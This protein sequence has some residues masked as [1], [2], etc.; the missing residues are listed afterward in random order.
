VVFTLT[1][2]RLPAAPPVHFVPAGRVKVTLSVSTALGA[3]F[4]FVVTVPATKLVPLP[5]ASTETATEVEPSAP[6]EFQVSIWAN[7]ERDAT[8]ALKLVTS[9]VTD[10]SAATGVAVEVSRV[11]AGSMLPQ[12]FAVEGRCTSL[13][14]G[15]PLTP[16]AGL[17]TKENKNNQG[18]SFEDTN[19]RYTYLGMACAEVCAA[20][21]RRRDA[22]ARTDLPPVNILS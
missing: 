1:R 19:K 7:R 21:A 10:P 22:Q 20:S 8:Y 15:A 14:A 18:L 2:Q 3:G 12:G 4:P 6:L 13:R 17:E 11:V 5:V 16:R 9:K